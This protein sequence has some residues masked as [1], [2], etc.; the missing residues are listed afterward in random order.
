[1]K[2]F[3][4]CILKK[5]ILC[6]TLSS[7]LTISLLTGC[8]GPSFPFTSSSE[9][10]KFQAFQEEL[11]K[12]EVC[13]NTL[14]LHYILS[15][16]A[17]FGL[18]DYK[19]TL[20]DISR[21]SRSRNKEVLNETQKQ[22]KDFHYFLLSD[23]EKLNYDLL[24]E[25]VD[26]Q[27]SLCDY[28][29]YSDMLSPSN[30]L[31]SQ[32]PMLFAEYKFRSETDIADYLE[33]LKLMHSYYKDVIDFEK[34]KSDAGL[35]MPDCLC[36]KVIK[37]CEDFIEHPE[38]NYLIT[39]FNHKIEEFDGISESDKAKYIE[40]NQ[41]IIEENVI[42]AYQ[43]MI[44][45]LTSLLGTGENDNGLCNYEDGKKYYKLL[46]EEETG[47]ED[48]VRKIEKR[49][50]DMRTEDLQICSELK[51]K[52]PNIAEESSNLDWPYEDESAM[53]STLQDE[54]VKDFPKM[55]DTDYQITYVDEALSDSLA[56][57]F[58]LTAPI[59]DYKE[60][61][62]YINHASEYDDIF[63]FATLAHEG[64]PGHL[65]QTVM[66]YEYGIAP[67]RSLLDYG[68]FTEGWATYV[69]MMSYYYAGL[70][71]DVAA[72][73][74]HSEAATFSLYASSDI[75]IHYHG[76]DRKQLY[77][78]WAGYGITDEDA[79]DE[80]RELI[81][82][83]PGNYLKYYVGY[84]EFEQLREEK[85]KQLGKK[86]DPVKFHEA[87]LKIGPAPFDIIDKYFDKYY[88]TKVKR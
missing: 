69:E 82:A 44:S 32:L 62:I 74:Q 39:T 38:E 61:N 18:N 79:V 27:A 34:D 80:I 8:K 64:F 66:S 23:S 84:L 36:L 31:Q 17:D 60:N 86:F 12:S 41:K 26:T 49:I 37:E 52:N 4:G 7:I 68:G 35:F 9:C 51:G 72:F 75:G 11:F 6:F 83:D 78:F 43:I 30:G 47:S 14:N 15:N 21:E 2:F 56:P 85:E 13:S 5:R 20:G 81:L 48:S 70:D 3:E 73:L 28:E 55:P 87:I 42:P 71:P 59:D 67:F 58:Y 63:Y 10:K 88:D 1:M 16:P 65:Y 19:I 29:L 57:A 33:L 77:D 50:D 40:Q 76:W 25:Y 22:L 54:L 45:G 46:V 24:S 53:I